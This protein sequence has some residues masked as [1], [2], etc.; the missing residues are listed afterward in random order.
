MKKTPEDTN[1]FLLLPTGGGN[2]GTPG[3]RFAHYLLEI[4]HR[5]L[6]QAS[7]L[8]MMRPS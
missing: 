5:A 7:C 4:Y 8:L 1:P 2:E 6:L 3:G